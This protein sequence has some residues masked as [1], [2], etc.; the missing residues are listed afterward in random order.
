MKLL[1]TS[2][3]FNVN[4][5]NI[6]NAFITLINKDVV[7]I[8]I[9]LFSVFQSESDQHYLKLNID[10]LVSLGFKRNNISSI[11]ICEANNENNFQNMDVL[12]MCWWNTYFIMNCLRENWYISDI[13]KYLNQGGIYIWHSAGSIILGPNI[14]TETDSNN[15]NLQDLNWLNIFDFW[16][17]PHFDKLSEEK[18]T[19]LRKNYKYDFVC[20]KDN[21]ALLINENQISIIS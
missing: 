12:Y 13:L 6:F 5:N 17:L 14:N 1:L 20:L 7:D 9:S 11:N 18:I 21:Q 4:T 19:K 15:I 8:K 3:G 2:E 16:I 10:L